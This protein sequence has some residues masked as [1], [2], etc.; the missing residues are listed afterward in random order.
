MAK[1]VGDLIPRSSGTSA[2]GVEITNGGPTNDLRPFA[3]AIANSGIFPDPKLAGSGVI[4]YSAGTHGSANI[5]L[6]EGRFRGLE[7]SYDGG[8]NFP[9][10]LVGGDGILPM[11][12]VESDGILLLQGSGFLT[13]IAQGSAR[14]ISTQQQTFESN[15]WQLYCHQQT[16]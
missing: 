1:E 11:A 10:R 2:L 16:D 7:V 13:A 12:G 14:Y 15:L 9:L 8:H 6:P 5:D 4:R 3:F